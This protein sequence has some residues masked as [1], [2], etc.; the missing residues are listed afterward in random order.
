MDETPKEPG[1]ELERLNELDPP[2]VAEERRQREIEALIDGRLGSGAVERFTKERSQ[3]I[4]RRKRE[5]KRQQKEQL[6]QLVNDRLRDVVMEATE[7]KGLTVQLMLY[8][9]KEA[10]VLDKDGNVVAVRD[11]LL[12]RDLLDFLK[13]G[14]LVGD[15]LLD[16][17]IGRPT[18]QVKVSHEHSLLDSL[19]DG[20]LQELEGELVDVE[21][22]FDE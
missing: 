21:E 1:F 17:L 22:E 19:S 18:A 13:H 4:A 8:R 5:H 2:E 7:L 3:E 14:N 16:R 12:D 20:E 11:E 15:K 9:L 6:E 10:L